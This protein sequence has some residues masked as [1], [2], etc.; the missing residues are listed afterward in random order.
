VHYAVSGFITEYTLPPGELASMLEQRGFESLWVPEHT[1][2]PSSRRSRWPGGDELPSDYWHAYDPFIALTAAAAATTTLKLGTGVCLVI[3]HDPIVLAKTVATLDRISGGR[4]IFGIGGGWNAEEMENHGTSFK[5][6]WRLL[7]ERV[8]AMKT[9]WTEDEA[10]FHGD[11]VDFDKIRAN[12]K[13][14]QNPHPPIFM[15][16]DGPS[17]FDRVVEFCDGWMPIGGRRE[18]PTLAEKI[19][20][21]RRRFEAAGRDPDALQISSF[22]A[23]PERDVVDRLA[24]AGV[25]RVIFGLPTAGREVVEPMLDQMASLIK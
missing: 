16:G 22:G 21:L 4:F 11:Y 20:A 15:G 7:R 8:L 6:R 17:T 14:V 13:P 10:E 5:T 19:T 18:G 25:D 9:I 24:A 2:I 23:S 1:H 3:E 12:P